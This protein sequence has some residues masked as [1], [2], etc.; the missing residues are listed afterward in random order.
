MASPSLHTPL[1]DWHQEHG[2][3]MVDF[4]GW[5]MPIQ[6]TSIVDEHVA[7]RTAI[8]M[9]DIS[10]MGRLHFDGP[11]APEFLD[12]LV[13][14]RIMGLKPGGVRYGLVTNAQGGILDDVL[15]YRLQ[16]PDGHSQYMMVV[17]A[18]NRE[19]ILSWIDQHQPKGDQVA[20]VDRTMDTAMIAV[21][22]PKAIELLDPLV[23]AD[24]ASMK[25][26]TG[27]FTTICGVDAAVSRTGYTG[28]DG[29][30]LIVP[31]G[32]A[33]KLW[34]ALLKHGKELGL[35]PAGLGARDTLRLEAGMPLY[36]HE[37]SE[38]INPV[39]A[40]LDFAVQLKDRDFIGREA[41]LAA[42]ADTNLPRRIGLKFSGR[43]PAREQYPVLRGDQRVGE[44]TSGTYSPTLGYP[45][46]MAYV[47]PEC[48][49]VGTSLTVDIRGRA[50]P[51]EVVALPFYT[52]T[53]Q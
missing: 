41:M 53:K 2:G 48:A 35:L 49:A 46:A 43:R 39:Q 29:C 20:V 23:A 12:R 14:R 40:G 15:V 45:I 16:R 34:L 33:V 11:A 3:R 8:G 30:E 10:H 21:Q 32:T 25:Y 50:T 24:L 38:R 19:K 6:Y 26:Y 51:A 44:I 7:T 13:T 17:N 28:E 22:G 31:S 5:S 36:G 18:S 9:F 47:T 37:L 1:S 27:L 4:A 42:K 52:R